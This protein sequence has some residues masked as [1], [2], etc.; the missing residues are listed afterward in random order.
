MKMQ[1]NRLVRDRVPELIVESGRKQISR[2]LKDEE[3]E[4]ALMDKIVEEIEEY[5]ISKNE[6]EIADIYEVL[7]CLVKLKEYE[8]MHIDY[9]RLIKREARG[10]FHDRI[11]LE[12]IVEDEE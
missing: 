11:L 6:E 1:Y 2:K 3:Y 10:S 8:P 4:Q 5:R 12:K 7:D 9:L